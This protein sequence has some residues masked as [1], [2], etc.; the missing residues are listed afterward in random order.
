M[1]SNTSLA[2]SWSQE[3]LQHLQQDTRMEIPILQ[4]LRSQNMLC[5]HWRNKNE[6]IYVIPDNLFSSGTALAN[7]C[8]FLSA[9][10]SGDEINSFLKLIQL[11]SI[12]SHISSSLWVNQFL[13]KEL[14][15]KLINST[16]AAT[17]TGLLLRWQ[18]YYKDVTETSAVLLKKKT[19]I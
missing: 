13:L 8:F 1:P 15:A 10:F 2:T 17:T 9:P 7:A 4:V 3:S 11:C 16:T 5:S 6:A 18:E 12:K 19:I 14:P